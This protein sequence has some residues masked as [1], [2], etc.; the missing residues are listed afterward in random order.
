MYKLTEKSDKTFE[1][2]NECQ[3]A[4]DTLKEK[5]INAPLL[6]LPQLDSDEFMILTVD[7]SAEAIEY[8]F[9]RYQTDPET[10]KRI[11]R[12]LYYGGKSLKSVASKYG[13]A[14]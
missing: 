11:V 7:T 4:F 14:H 9:S 10:N 12:V 1:W 2:S 3:I 5:W 13:S 6:A 8:V